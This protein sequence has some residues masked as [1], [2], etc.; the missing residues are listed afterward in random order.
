[1]ALYGEQNAVSTTVYASADGVTW[2]GPLGATVRAD[3]DDDFYISWDD[4]PSVL[5]SDPQIYIAFGNPD[6]SPV[7]LADGD[8]LQWVDLESKFKPTQF[9]GVSGGTF[10]SG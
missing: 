7:P 2:E 4:Y 1:M 3:S 6:T 9:D 8:I 10:G 5:C